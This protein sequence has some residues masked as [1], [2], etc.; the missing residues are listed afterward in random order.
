MDGRGRKV[1][2][3][4]KEAGTLRKRWEIGARCRP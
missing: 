3:G 1:N 4:V 2:K